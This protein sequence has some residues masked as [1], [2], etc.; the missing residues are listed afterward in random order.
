MGSLTAQQVE[1]FYKYGFLKV[2][3]ILDPEEYLDPI[4]DEYSGV[5][6]RLAD[7]LYAEGEITSRYEDLPFGDRVTAIYAE[8]GKQFSGYFDICLPFMGVTEETPF[9]TGQA[10]LNAI[11]AEPLLDAVESF[12]GAEIY[13]NP[14]QHVRIKPPEQLLPKDADGNPVIGATVWHQDRGTVTEDADETDMI[15]AWFSL[16]D[17]A[18]EQG[19]LKIVPQSHDSGLLTHCLSYKGK[20]ADRVIPEHLFD[21]DSTIPMPTKRGDVIF[22]HRQTVHGSLANVSDKIR[23]SFD[24]RYNP[25]GQPTGRG[26][27]PGFV[28]RSRKNPESELRDADVWTDMWRKA[29]TKMASVNQGDMSDVPFGRWT[30]GHPDCA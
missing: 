7:E 8:T 15:T 25:I 19:P 22:L 29:R 21:I 26:A 20:K 10:V 18:I 11:T 2:D 24:L 6:D 13:S 28:A 3:G 16:T 1:G 23:W 17:A 27:F 9:W 5:L 14:V 12:I 4:I 30:E